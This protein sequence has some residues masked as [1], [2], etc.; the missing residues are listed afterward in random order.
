[1]AL[2]AEKESFAAL[3]EE[4]MGAG[5]NLEG[6]VVKGT[7]V[8]IENDSAIID[9]GLKSEGRVSLKEFGAPGTALDLKVGDVVEVFLERMEDKNGEAAL[10]RD[11]ARREEAWNQLEKAFQAQT[12]VN[13]VIFG[14]VKGGFTVDLSGAVAFLPGS[15]VDIRPVRDITPL[16]GTP[17]P[18]QILKMDRRRGNIVVSRRAVLEESRAE[19]RSELVAS[20]KEGQVLQGVVKNIT[21]YGAFVD[22]G[23]VDGLLHVTDIAWRR[24]NHPSEALN[25][26]QAV[27]VQVIRFNPDTQR[28]SLG[29]KQLEADPWEGVELKYPA[30]AKFNGRVTN[31]TDY[32]AFVELE[33]GIE[34]LVHVSEMSWTKKNVHPGKIVSTSQEV[35]VMVL[36]VDPVKRRISLG[37]KQCL[38]NPWQSFVDK[39]PA[40]TELSGEVK[41]I[42]EFG[43]FVGLPGDIDGMVHL[44][45]LSWEKSGEEAIQD[46]KKGDQVKV[47]VLDVD[48]EKERISLGIKQLVND[49]FEKGLESIRKG[50]VITGKVTQVQD[51]GIEVEIVEGITGFIRKAELARDRQ[52]QRPERFAVGEKVDAKVVQIDKAARKITL[53]IKAR[54]VEEDKQAMAEY[55]SSDSGASLGDILGAA[56]RKARSKDQAEG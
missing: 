4:S 25:I 24:I 16:M 30:G 46:Y 51:N 48:V 26:G 22:L 34:G 39:Y 37:L 36:D 27:T 38:D 20:L 32:G 33:P 3:L 10:S 47:R 29:M 44:S 53:S 50:E 40:N 23:G 2:V 21:D 31:I 6:T 35:E 17:Q 56:I 15:Q 18:F 11:K 5:E 8:A 13:G 55:G 1:M 49:P 42:T 14:R 28:I 12:R 7:I 9:V 41:N 43:L 45:D 52:D 54:E 19:A